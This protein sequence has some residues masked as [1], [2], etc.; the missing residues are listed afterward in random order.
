MNKKALLGCALSLNFAHA[1]RK[2]RN[3]FF[4]FANLR[5][6]AAKNF[7]QS[8]EVREILDLSR[9]FVLFGTVK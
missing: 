4:I 2:K 6:S 9:D 3:A 5:S 1:I 7:I 8:D